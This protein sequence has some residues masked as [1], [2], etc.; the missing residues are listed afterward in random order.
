MTNYFF[1]VTAPAHNDLSKVTA[2]T[3]IDLFGLRACSYW[4]VR[5]YSVCSCGFIWVTCML[6]L[7]CPGL[8][9][10]LI[11]IYL[12]YVHAH[13]DLS[14]LWGVLIL[15]YPVKSCLHAG[16]MKMRREFSGTTHT[17]THTHTPSHTPTRTTAHTS[18]YLVQFPT[19]F[20]IWITV[21][22][23]VY[24]IFEFKKINLLQT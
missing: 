15:I 11:L 5:G 8:Q 18:L 22:S 10:V 19:L 17:H 12:G 7:I 6:I 9:R 24:D 20:Y 21:T 16:T 23:Y 2:R 4:F 1:R 14:G 13:I 3:H